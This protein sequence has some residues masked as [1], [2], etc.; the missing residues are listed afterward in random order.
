MLNMEWMNGF[1]FEKPWQNDVSEENSSIC[2]S[3]TLW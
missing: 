3:V 2:I 1:L